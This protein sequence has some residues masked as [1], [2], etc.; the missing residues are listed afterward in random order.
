MHFVGEVAKEEDKEG[1]LKV[2]FLKKHT[3]VPNSFVEVDVEDVQ[4]VPI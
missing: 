1:N 3:K 2:K 4:S